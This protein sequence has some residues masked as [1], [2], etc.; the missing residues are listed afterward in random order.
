MGDF[1]RAGQA[2][3]LLEGMTRTR[4]H[5]EMLHNLLQAALHRSF[6]VVERLGYGPG[7]SLPDARV[8]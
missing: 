5:L 2:P 3:E 4:L 8:N 6:L 7:D 1:V